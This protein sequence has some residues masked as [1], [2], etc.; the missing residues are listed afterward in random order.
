MEIQ[1]KPFAVAAR[2]AGP[3]VCGTLLEECCLAQSARVNLHLVHVDKEFQAFVESLLLDRREPMPIWRPGEPFVL[4]RN[5]QRM[6]ILQDVGALTL[7]DQHHL[8]KW[9]EGPGRHT[10]IVTTTPEPLLPRV[11]DGT[12][13]DSLYYRLNVVYVDVAAR[14]DN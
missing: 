3:L 14:W 9:L 5:G 11:D 8:L 1:T 6:M 13:L 4:P 12:F 2:T 10:Q 7:E